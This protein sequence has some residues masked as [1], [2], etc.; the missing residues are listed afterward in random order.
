LDRANTNHL[1]RPFVFNC[2]SS[3]ASDAAGISGA[4]TPYFKWLRQ[5]LNPFFS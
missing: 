4:S 1:A 3:L 5:F 2:R